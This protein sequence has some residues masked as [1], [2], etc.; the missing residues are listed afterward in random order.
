MKLTS[1][2]LRDISGRTAKTRIVPKVNL[3]SFSP[4]LRLLIRRPAPRPAAPG[5]LGLFGFDRMMPA[6]PAELR[7]ACKEG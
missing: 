5:Y 1:Q 6:D 3:I 4:R 2:D 7:I